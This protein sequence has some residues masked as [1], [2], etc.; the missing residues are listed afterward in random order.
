MNDLVIGDVLNRPKKNE[1]VCPAGK[2]CSGHYFLLHLPCLIL[3]WELVGHPKFLLCLPGNRIWEDQ[4]DG[5]VEKEDNADVD[6]RVPF[7]DKDCQ[8]EGS[9]VEDEAGEDE[10]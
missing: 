9:R 10:R 4:T 2:H 7:G 1:Q 8:D 6:R 5:Q 3:A